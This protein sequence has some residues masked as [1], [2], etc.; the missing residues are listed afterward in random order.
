MVGKIIGKENLPGP[1]FQNDVR[2]K[3][4]IVSRSVIK[5]GVTVFEKRIA[6]LGQV[7]LV[8][9]G[10]RAADVSQGPGDSLSDETN[11]SE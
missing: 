1:W 5:G 6:F 2:G 8:A 9:S 7:P 4:A 10:A 11:V 3:A